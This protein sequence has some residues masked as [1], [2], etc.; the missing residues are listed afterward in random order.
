MPLPARTTGVVNISLQRD[1]TQK[2][3]KRVRTAVIAALWIVVRTQ[4]VMVGLIRT[5]LLSMQ[6]K[7]VV[8]MDMIK[9]LS[10]AAPEANNVA[11]VMIFLIGGRYRRTGRRSAVQ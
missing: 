7:Y 1:L 5:G 3:G 6:T 2:N 10:G 4:K 8:I 9:W 11:V